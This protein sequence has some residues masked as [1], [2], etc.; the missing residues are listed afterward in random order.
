MLC[1]SDGSLT[2]QPVAP[3]KRIA[4]AESLIPG[5]C[6]HR[7]GSRMRAYGRAQAIITAA[8]RLAMVFLAD[9]W[10]R[11]DAW[12]NHHFSGS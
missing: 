11:T 2:L 10:S 9:G 5:R 4:F 1:I 7:L 3:T 12:I 6:I 8:L